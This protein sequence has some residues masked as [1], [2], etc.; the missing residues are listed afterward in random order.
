[1]IKKVLL[2]GLAVVGA[3][4]VIG[5]GYLY[6]RPPVMV[7]PSKIKV[8]ITEGRLSRGEYLFDKAAGCAECHSEREFTRF[9]GPVV[10]EM[11]GAGF[12]YPTELG[13]PGRV[14]SPNITP[15]KETGIGNWTD[16]EIIRAIREGV[17]RDGRTLFPLMPY[18]NFRK[19]SDE[20][21][22]SVVAYLRTLKPVKRVLPP[23]HINF[24][25]S[26]FIKS[27][28]RPA[29]TVRPVDPQDRFKYGEYL[30]TM[31]GCEECHTPAERGEPIPGKRLAGGRVFRTPAGM[32]VSANISPDPDTGI[33]KYSEQDFLN[34]FYQY[35]KYVVEGSPKVG[36]E[37]FTV[38]P[39]LFF[40][41]MKE[42]DLKAI[43]LYLKS[44]PPVYNSVEK[45]PEYEQRGRTPSS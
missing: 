43:F 39:W 32:V 10:P 25:V 2:Y 6:F 24:P 37:S 22:Y 26:M 5:F 28:P 42:E 14:V 3:V 13:F 31:G 16:G 15:D 18:P 27:V 12:I 40:C 41:Q 38:M 23:T 17:T 4:A 19:M 44:Q 36:P 1:L 45:H 7:P 30:F 29:G 35:K 9:G 20:D 33:G 21:V 8:E 11:K 34:K